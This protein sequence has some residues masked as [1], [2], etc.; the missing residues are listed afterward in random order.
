M[1]NKVMRVLPLEN[2]ELNELASDRDRFAYEGLNCRPPR[3][4]C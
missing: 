3:S 1:A 4:P 2:E